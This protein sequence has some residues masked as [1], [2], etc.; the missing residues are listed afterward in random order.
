MKYANIQI[1]KYANMQICKYTN[2]QIYKYANMQIYKYT[3]VVHR[4]IPTVVSDT[5]ISLCLWIITT[6]GA[7][8][9]I[10]NNSS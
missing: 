7:F 8:W 10:N 6:P 1:Y 3:V 9:E 4:L 2:M 5:L